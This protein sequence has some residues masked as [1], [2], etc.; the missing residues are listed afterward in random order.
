MSQT[1]RNL[2]ATAARELRRVSKAEIITP[3]DR[4]YES[5]RKI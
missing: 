2:S 1:W 3:E 4:A 5:A